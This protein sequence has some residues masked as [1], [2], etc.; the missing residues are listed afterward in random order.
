VP[1]GRPSHR[2]VHVRRVLAT[3]APAAECEEQAE[4]AKF[5]ILECMC[6]GGEQPVGP[7]PMSARFGTGA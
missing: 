1:D 2:R 7:A 6:W 5:R 3:R 4:S